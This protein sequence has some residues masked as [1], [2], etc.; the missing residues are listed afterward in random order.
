M[1]LRPQLQHVTYLCGRD[2]HSTPMK[3]PQVAGADNITF[4][5]AHGTVD[6]LTL[7][8]RITIITINI[9]GFS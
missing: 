8:G 1:E 7:L 4:M 3:G 9:T 5:A 6:D 2:V